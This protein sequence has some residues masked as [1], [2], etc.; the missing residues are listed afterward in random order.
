[1]TRA[2]RRRQESRSRLM[3]A[4]RKVFSELG[5]H[6][7]SVADILSAAGM[8]RGTFYLYFPSKRAVFEALLDEMFVHIAQAVRRVSTEVGAEPPLEQM[9]WNVRRLVDAVETHRELT[10]ILLREAGGIDA[11]F[12][13]KLDRFYDRICALIQSGLVDGQARGLVRRCDVRLVSY[14]VLGSLKEAMLRF[15]AAEQPMD[16]EE[17]VREILTYVLHGIFTGPADAATR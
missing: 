2:Q 9:Y 7:A 8:A 12:D 15:L 13:R 10:V 1:M 16:R 5:Y 14:L 4:S 17:L 3:S 11:D 6:A